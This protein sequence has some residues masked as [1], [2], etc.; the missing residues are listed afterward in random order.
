MHPP[1][2]IEP[3]TKLVVGPPAYGAQWPSGWLA[4]IAT[5]VATV[6][7]TVDGDTAELPL[8]GRAI[9]T[10]EDASDIDEEAIKLA[11]DIIP[12]TKTLTIFQVTEHPPVLSI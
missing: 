9:R 3:D 7:A 8:V 4:P 5:S 10:D 2:L 1:A 11:P 6:D 12:T